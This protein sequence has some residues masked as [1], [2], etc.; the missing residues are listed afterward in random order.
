LSLSN[1][2]LLTY[3]KTGI[4]LNHLETKKKTLSIIFVFLRDLIFFFKLIYFYKKKNLNTTM[5]YKEMLWVK[6]QLIEQ[7]KKLEMQPLTSLTLKPA[8]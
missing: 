1:I 8:L 3:K 7:Q 2:I 5:P 4:V 6:F